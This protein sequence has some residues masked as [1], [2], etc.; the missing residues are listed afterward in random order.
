MSYTNCVKMAS[1]EP[2]AIPKRM[3]KYS[4]GFDLMS[5]QTITILPHSTVLVATAIS[6]ALPVGVC[7]LVLG[8]S[9]NAKN[10]KLLVHTGLIDSDYREPLSI[11]VHSLNSEPIVIPKNFRL[12]QLLFLNLYQGLVENVDEIEE[13]RD[14]ERIGGFGST[15]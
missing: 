8:R 10:L 1:S 7:A 4:C 12:A 3:T 9:S 6:V 15:N 14:S 5:N 11:L 13:C 2:I